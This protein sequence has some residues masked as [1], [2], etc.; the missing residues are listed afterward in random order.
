MRVALAHEY[1][2]AW[3]GAE[4]VTRALH[5]EW[6]AAP[7]Y[8]LF[9]EPRHRRALAGWDVRTSWLQRLP[10]GG[11]RHRLLLPLLPRAVRSIAV[12]PVDVLVS[13]S[14]AFIKGLQLPDGTRHV[15][16]C[17]SPTRYLWDWREQYLAE[18]VPLPLRP[19]VAA[20]L[21]ELRGWDREAARRVDRF[22]ANSRTVRERIRRYYE[23]DADVVHPP[24]DVGAFT[25]GGSQ[26]EDFYLLVSRLV[27]YK[28]VDVAVRA[29]NILGTRLKIASEGRDR[30]RLERLAR[31]NVE[32]L[33][34]QPDASL[35]DL[36]AVARGFV[37]PA[38][39]DFGMVMAEALASGTPV[40]ALG[41]GGATEIVEDGLTGV[42]FDEPTPE[43]LVAAVRRAETLSF[44]PAALR[45]SA[46][47]FDAS[48]FRERM[49]AI[50]AEEASR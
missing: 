14:S 15:C 2:A 10:L 39:D 5:E 49:R 1:F 45:R 36:L 31:D 46:E 35:R 30:G 20:V 32:F 33:G 43:A 40:I 12:D 24:I 23:T 4:Q 44:D 6:P 3:G 41:R 26:R 29:F 7:V 17:H 21:E 37:F 18:E 13:S 27:P 22:I 11:G 28:N 38:E 16:Y 50:V 42:L 19:L 47:R 9:A 8:T 25:L 34:R 48:I